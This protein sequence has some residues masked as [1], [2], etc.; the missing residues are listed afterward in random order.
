MPLPVSRGGPGLR[1]IACFVALHGFHAILCVPWQAEITVLWPAF[2]SKVWVHCRWRCSV[3]VFCGGVLWRCSVAGVL[4]QADFHA[5]PVICGRLHVI[6][7]ISGSMAL[8]SVLWH[9]LLPKTAMGALRRL[10]WL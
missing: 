8:L 5:L 1:V 4:W 2:S 3:A 7:T 9:D 6:W 10:K